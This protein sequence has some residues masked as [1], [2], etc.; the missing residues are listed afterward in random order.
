MPSA[1]AMAVSVAGCCDLPH[2]QKTIRPILP[3][4]KPTATLEKRLERHDETGMWSDEG[5]VTTL[6]TTDVFD[7]IL[8]RERWKAW[9]LALEAAGRWRE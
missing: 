8:I 4:G 7:L 6:P 1:L 5:A 9:A 2:Y 3:P